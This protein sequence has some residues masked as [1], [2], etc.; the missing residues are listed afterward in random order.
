[1]VDFEREITPDGIAIVRVGGWL[2]KFSCP[3]FAGCME[4]L[5]KDGFKE[6]IID[7]SDLGLI[8]NSCLNNL[9]RP[10]NRLKD[11]N[12]KVA[13]VDVNTPITKFIGLLGLKKLFGLYST[14]ED[15][16]IPARKR[17]SRNAKRVNR[18]AAAA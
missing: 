4:D 9:I 18:R 3:Y 13:L 5:A 10:S 11:S 7:C 12:S 2:E 17:M 14:V 6:I 1:M 8:S 15:A 16:L